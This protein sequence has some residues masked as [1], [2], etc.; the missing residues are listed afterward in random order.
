[1]TDDSIYAALKPGQRYTLSQLAKKHNV[2][3]SSLRVTLNRM[4]DAQMIQ[5][6]R[7]GKAIVF[8]VPH[9]QAEIPKLPAMKVYRVP[10]VMQEHMER[11]QVEREIKSRFN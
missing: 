4:I 5:S 2:G 1:M 9:A 3:T 11:V 7:Q 8:Y 10:T 6:E